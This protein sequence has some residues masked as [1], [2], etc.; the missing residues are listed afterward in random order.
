MNA[1]EARFPAGADQYSVNE[2]N[3]SEFPIIIVNLTG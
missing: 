3:F 2:I 1:A